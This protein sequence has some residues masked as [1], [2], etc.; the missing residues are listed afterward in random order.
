MVRL[1][2]AIAAVL[3]FALSA[4]ACSGYL[5]CKYADGSHC[6]VSHQHHN[7]H[8]SASDANATGNMSRSWTH[9]LT[10]LVRTS[11]LVGPRG[12]RSALARSLANRVLRKF[13]RRLR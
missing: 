2:T 9:P 13:F 3:A 12:R 6:C 8:L 1:F 7:I 5:Q 10:V 4:E 11:A